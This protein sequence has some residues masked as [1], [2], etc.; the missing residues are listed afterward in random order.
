MNITLTIP[1]PGFYESVLSQE[2]DREEEMLAGSL[3]GDGDYGDVD[4]PE[5]PGVSAS[6][7][8]NAIYNAASYR[9][10]HNAL[11]RSWSE[12]FADM[13]ARECNVK[14]ALTFESMHSPREYNFTTDRVF[15]TLPVEDFAIMRAACDAEA[16]ADILREE[17]TSRDGFSSFYSNDPEDWDKPLAEYDHNEAG[18]VLLAYMRT[19]WEDYDDMAVFERLTEGSAFS[20]ALD[21]AIDWNKL[22]A[23]LAEKQGSHA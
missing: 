23:E 8:C 13:L 18:A 20:E 21:E 3:T 16:F 15:V 4:G 12:V 10:A 22:R 6:D 17:F 11:A 2:L 5:F 7:A 14:W 9:D 1:F 19:H